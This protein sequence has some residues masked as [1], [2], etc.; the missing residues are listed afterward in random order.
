LGRGFCDAH[1]F[2]RRKPFRRH[3]TPV[4]SRPTPRSPSRRKPPASTGGFLV[5]TINQPN[6]QSF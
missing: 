2:P 5:T 3:R 4:C 6:Q 1:T